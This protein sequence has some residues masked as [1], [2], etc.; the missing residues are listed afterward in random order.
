MQQMIYIIPFINSEWS[1]NLVKSVAERWSFSTM[2]C[3]I[4]G[5]SILTRIY[6]FE[7]LLHYIVVC[8][9]KVGLCACRW[10]YINEGNPLPIDVMCIPIQP[11]FWTWKRERHYHCEWHGK[12]PPG[13]M[14]WTQSQHGYVSVSLK[15]VQLKLTIV[16]VFN[17][18]QNVV[19]M[20]QS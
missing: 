11:A 3:T 17:N 7:P 2:N 14:T 10:Y 4:T 18:Q 13:L 20:F 6:S 19:P 16:V 12:Y 1:L 5:Q 9:Q 8:D 15:Y